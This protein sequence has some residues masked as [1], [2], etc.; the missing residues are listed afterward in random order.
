MGEYV[1]IFQGEYG[2]I[3]WWKNKKKCVGYIVIED[4]FYFKRIS[5]RRHEINNAMK[6]FNQNSR[7]E[8]FT[9]ERSGERKFNENKYNAKQAEEI[10]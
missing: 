8:V 9:L 10:S 6:K 7:H 4:I 2:A 3:L 1:E 5:C